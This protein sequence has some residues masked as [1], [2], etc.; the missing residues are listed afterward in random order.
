MKINN[1]YPSN[2]Q[3]EHDYIKINNLYVSHIIIECLPNEID[4]FEF[5]KIVPKNIENTVSIS[6]RKKDV[7]EYIKRI[8]KII[9]E[10][11]SELKSL[12]NNMISKDMTRKINEEALEFRRKLQ[13]ENEDVYGMNI[14]ISMFDV[15]LDSLKININKM[16]SNLYAKNIYAKVANFRQDD[17]YLETLPINISKEVLQKQTAI[18]VTSSQLAYLIPYIKNNI[19]DKNGIL[20]GYINKTFCIYDIFSKRAMNHNM[21]V[22]GSSGSGKSFFLKTIILRNFCMNIRQVV[23]DIEEEYLNLSNKTNTIEFNIN[24]FNLLYIPKIFAENNEKDFLN[25]KIQSIIE[26]FSQI[27]NSNIT[28][29][30]DEIRKTLI[31]T[32]ERYKITVDINSLYMRDYNNT[33][34]LDKEYRKYSSFPNIKDLINR[35]DKK[36]KVPKTII[37]TLKNSDMY[38]SYDKNMATL[39]DDKFDNIIVFNMKSLGIEKFST[40]IDFAMQYFSQELLIYIDE[41]WKYMNQNTKENTCKI[42]GELYK[43]I[44]KKNAGIVIATQDI[45]DILRFDDGIFGKSILNNSY[46]K[47]FFKMQYFDISLLKEIGIYSE[48][49]IN[50]IKKLVI[51]SACMLVGDVNFNIDIKASKNEVQII[52]GEAIEKNFSSNK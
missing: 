47:L 51:G 19:Y 21:C 45:H 24:N 36:T 43:T 27:I 40:L 30:E 33:F 7:N 49:I 28:E 44:R 50:S 46:T 4:M 34:V 35:L 18:D 20:Y 26:L 41:V 29:Y 14:Y 42:I 6:I 3:I 32:Y 23:F 8:S 16:L 31:E 1:I 22:L 11:S 17:V 9:L 5:N 13:V 15:N 48:E 52:G 12:N 10:S 37:K 39:L 25:K 2:I 38:K